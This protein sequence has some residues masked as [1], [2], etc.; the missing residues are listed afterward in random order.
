[1]STFR[2]HANSSLGYYG[3]YLLGIDRLFD[4]PQVV[5]TITDMPTVSNPRD[6]LAVITPEGRRIY[7]AADDHVAV[8]EEALAWCDVYG[9]VNT[10]A[11]P[12]RE[13]IPI[14]PSFGVRWRSTAAS[15]RYLWAAS[16]HQPPRLRMARLKALGRDRRARRDLSSYVPTSAG[17]TE[18]FHAGSQWHRHPGVADERAL[19]V[20]A[21]RSM[22]EITFDGGVVG[23]DDPTVAAPSRYTYDEYL[24]RT[25]RSFVVFNGPAVHGCLGW[26]LGEYLAL[27]KAIITTPLT[28]V[29]PE[30]L[31]HGRHVHIVEPSEAAFVE[32][33]RTLH[34][35]PE[36]RIELERNARAYWDRWLA[37]ERVITRLL[38]DEGAT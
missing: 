11:S 13:I 25:R 15:A 5:P 10:G 24:E 23:S 38:A 2:V 12:S 6:G 35:D 21:A 7:I 22:P 8:D 30:P 34:D 9:K 33:I 31:E 17:D 1:M 29:L 20:R 18:L 16:A 26:K 4:R 19:F 3:F 27:G 37:P 32:A 36:Y 28:H 14:G